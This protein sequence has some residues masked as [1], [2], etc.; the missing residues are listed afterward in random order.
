MP[1][2][3]L[4]DDGILVGEDGQPFQINGETVEV[5]GAMSQTKAERTIQERLAR[6]N[7]RI[8]E[9]EKAAEQTPSLQKTLDELRAERT[10]LEQQLAQAKEAAQAEVAGQI[11]AAQERAATLE[12]SLQQERAARVREQVTSSLL[13]AAGNEFLN[14]AADV[15][16]R[17][18]GAHKR[19]P[20]KGPDGKETGEYLD[21]FK[22]TVKD[23]KGNP[24]ERFVPAKDALEAFKQEPSNQHYLAAGNR[25]GSGGSDGANFANLDRAKMSVP[26]KAA[27]IKAHGSEAYDRLPHSEM[28]N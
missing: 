10:E 24:V 12:Q 6:Q 13:G 20:V 21:L 25:G 14:P 8:K 11:K 7:A 16:P 28:K 27:F 4:N 5:E 26:E 19:E 23:D 22:V 18:L 15:V 3:K 1:K 17:L 2:L 9:L